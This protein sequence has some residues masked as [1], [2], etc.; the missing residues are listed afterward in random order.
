MKTPTITLKNNRLMALLTIVF[1]ILILA[2]C[3]SSVGDS[4]GAVSD[5]TEII[6]SGT[7]TITYTSASEDVLSY[8]GSGGVEQTTLIFTVNNASDEAVVNVGVNFS[9]EG[10]SATLEN[11]SDVSDASGQVQ[12]VVSS[13]TIPGVFSVTATTG[14]STATSADITITA[15]TPTQGRISVGMDRNIADAYNVVGTDN[16]I[17]VIV[18]DKLG[19]P[20]LDGTQVRFIS[21]NCGL[22]TPS[23][24]TS[25]GEC[26]ATWSST[27]IQNANLQCNIL[28]YTTGQEN[29]NDVNGNGSF[30][31]G[32]DNF[33]V[34]DHDIGE[35]FIDINNNNSYD[36][37]E[38]FVDFIVN[39]T[40]DIADGQWTEST[41]IFSVQPFV[42][43]TGDLLV[44][45]SVAP[46]TPI[47]DGDTITVTVTD[48]AGNS[49]PGGTTVV[50]S[51]NGSVANASVSIPDNN[52][53]EYVETY[54][55]NSDGTSNIGN[56]ILT[57]DP[58]GNNGATLTY[59]WPLTD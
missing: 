10:I 3:G 32:V 54:T 23:C 34:V 48:S 25:N 51:G 58:A 56:L 18:T 55:I 26:T 24:S 12:A 35:P 53:G 8:Q 37:G 5:D 4:D 59:S 28:V 45:F 38:N 29:F 43:S 49:A 16:E 19:N 52:L 20:V 42:L 6:N 40:Y 15:G 27:G 1:G 9:I 30:D 21:P 41:A 31:S 39:N 33:V 2:A 11:T 36:S 47:N 57:I 14:S 50:F 7:N 13:G 44:T 22:V 17:N 46:D